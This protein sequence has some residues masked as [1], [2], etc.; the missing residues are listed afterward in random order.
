MNLIPASNK[1]SP[2]AYKESELDMLGVP[3]KLVKFVVYS[4]KRKNWKK[5]YF[6]LHKLPKLQ[7][8]SFWFQGILGVNQGAESLLDLSFMK[9]LQQRKMAASIPLKLIPTKIV[10]PVSVPNLF[11]SPIITL[12][13]FYSI[14]PIHA[15][16]GNYFRGCNQWNCMTWLN[17]TGC[18]SLKGNEWNL[19]TKIV[20]YND[21][22]WKFISN[23]Y[24]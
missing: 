1:I 18:Y 9:I 3:R 7:S 11:P 12:F 22:F 8:T 14:W 13:K 20:A 4:S 21:F 10:A 23:S 2:W 15:H 16:V 24:Y 17:V 6:S 19:I 5:I